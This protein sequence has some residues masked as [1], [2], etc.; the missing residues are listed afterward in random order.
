MELAFE[1]LTIEQKRSLLANL[2]ASSRPMQ[3]SA[4]QERL[5]QLDQLQPGTPL[6]NFQIAVELHGGLRVQAL[7]VAALQVVLR[8][9]VLQ[10]AYGVE[11]GK[12]AL[13]LSPPRRVAI[14]QHDLSKLTEHA[15]AEQMEAIGVADVGRS[16]NLAQPPLL[17]LTLVRLSPEKHRLYLTM[18]HIVSDFL[19]LDL[20]LFEMGACYSAMLEEEPVAL[21]LVSASY[22]D[23]VEFQRRTQ[24]QRVHQDH[25]EF[26][27][28]TLAGAPV[29]E[30]YSD[31]PRPV[32]A[33]G[34]AGTE[35]FSVPAEL[36]QKV[37]VFASTHRVTSFMVL[38]AAFKVLLYGC[39]GQEELIVGS[40]T[41]GRLRSEYEC[42]IGAFSHPLLIRSSM[43]G[44]RSFNEFLE[45]LRKVILDA[46]EHAD[47]PLA[48]VLESARQVGQRQA[49]LLRAMFSYVSRLHDLHFKD[50]DC[51]RCSTNRGLTDLDLFM[52][53]Y[54]DRGEWRGV[55]EYS[56][57]LFVPGTIRGM[58]T[59][60]TAILQGAIADPEISL[61]E[62]AARVPLKSARVVIAATFTADPLLEALKFWAKELDL[63]FTPVLCPFNQV[64][65]QLLA[66]DSLLKRPGNTLNILLLR[67]EDWVRYSKADAAH[68]KRLLE[69]SVQECID[70]VRN[71]TQ[72]MGCPLNIVLCPASPQLP[73]DMAFNISTAERNIRQELQ[74]LKNVEVLDGL[75]LAEEYGAEEIHDPHS[76]IAANIPYKPQFYASLG[77][78]VARRFRT[79]VAKPYKVL[80]LDC[81]NTLWQGICAEDGPQ[82]VV[83]TEGH[84]ALQI[85]ALRQAEAG[86]LLCLNSK[87]LPEHVFAVFQNHPDMVLKQE[88]IT[89]FRINWERKSS[90]ILALAAELNLGTDTFAFMDDDA[91]ECAEM[92]AVCPDVL[93]LR[94]PESPANLPVFLR[95]LWAFDRETVS[96]EDRSRAAFYRDNGR[97]DLA[98]QQSSSFTEFL[99]AL[100]LRV[101][102]RPALPGQMERIAQLSQRTNQ[103]NAS[104]LVFDSLDLQR[105]DTGLE[106]LAVDVGDRFGEYGLAG[107]VMARRQNECLTVE[108]FYLSCRVLGRGVEHRI[109]VELG[110][111]AQAAGLP[112]ICI[113]YSDSSRNLPFRRFLDHLPGVLNLRAN[114]SM[115]FCLTAAQAI[116][117]KLDPAEDAPVAPADHPAAISAGAAPSRCTVALSGLPHDLATARQVVARLR[118]A[119]AIYRDKQSGSAFVAPGNELENVIASE[120][121][122]VL[123]LDKVGRNDNFFELGG[124]SLLL[125]ELNSNLMRRLGV[126]LGMSRMFQFPTVASLA[127]YLEEAVLSSSDVSSRADKARVFFER[128]KNLNSARRP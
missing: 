90:N 56:A 120:W 127:G 111:I 91:R 114:G 68:Q 84:R 36:M 57:D 45:K 59:A 14:A 102:V 9:E 104:G 82:G 97:R 28:R 34:R 77:T 11:K 46:A 123:R 99:A 83:I 74:G 21:P 40:P 67:P 95:N 26:W 112:R 124:N 23:F 108:A 43:A 122:A 38:L 49:S 110:R 22:Q 12:P 25:I 19:S 117:A 109:L 35:F 96:D 5:W 27:R 118:A 63:R 41:A 58:V 13:F 115:E 20:F 94:L 51:R 42:L 121:Q 24:A 52:T 89:A 119:G 126:D 103:F 71:A 62:L 72:H 3:L 15:Q 17:R 61:G 32:Q 100:E 30:W 10:T 47:V 116:Q 54:A 6:Y 76:D 66:P 64:L 4:T 55:L 7:E 88:N 69:R 128:R 8:H 39:C 60:F 80:V 85:F 65:Q 31:H 29:P 37:E 93:T 70:A 92:T 2:V 98:R 107:A 106:V 75:S 113:A 81:D 44:C 16:F 53:L 1:T 125:V 78:M 48:Q 105:T 101:D 73:D 79:R 86:V 87:N 33:T 18:H 50:L